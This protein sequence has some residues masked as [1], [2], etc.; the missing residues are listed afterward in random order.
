VEWSRGKRAH[1]PSPQQ[2]REGETDTC[3]LFAL[4]VVV[5]CV[6]D[7]LTCLVDLFQKLSS[8]SFPASKR[9]ERK[10]FPTII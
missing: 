5:Q 8:S 9:K 6:S 3:L 2:E 10:V 7:G 4:L 1:D